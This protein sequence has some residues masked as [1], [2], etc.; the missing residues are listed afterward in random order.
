MN[1]YQSISNAYPN[2]NSIALLGC[3]VALDGIY[4]LI[5]DIAYNSFLL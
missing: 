2:S 3:S 5:I 1:F 4:D